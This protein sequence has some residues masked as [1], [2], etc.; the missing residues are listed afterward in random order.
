M[1]EELIEETEVDMSNKLPIIF[2]VY[3]TLKRKHGNNILL[4]GSEFLGEFKTNEEYTLYDGG[5]PIVCRDGETSIHCELFKT[6]DEYVVRRVFS[7]EGCSM[8]QNHP[9]SWYDY[10]LIQT[11]FGEAVMFVMNEGT[12]SRTNIIKSGKWGY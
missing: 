7:L 9:N 2:C 12:H 3:G 8:I 6:N 5:F 11:P 10:D 1:Q 4:K